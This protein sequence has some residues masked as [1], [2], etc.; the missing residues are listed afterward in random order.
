MLETK[1]NEKT[2][3]FFKVMGYDVETEINYEKDENLLEINVI[4]LEDAKILIGR[5]GSVLSCIQLLLRRI[6]K[7]ELE[8]DVYI[9][10]DIDNYKKNKVNSYKSIANSAAEEVITTMQEKVLPPL[11]SF[12]RRIIHLELAKRDDVLTESIGEGDQRRLVVKPK[13]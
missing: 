4:N 8:K 6:L 1:V 2:K 7:K 5:Q 9:F 3:E 12:A 13:L 10:L 11:S